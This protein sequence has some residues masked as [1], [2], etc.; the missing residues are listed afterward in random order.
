MK[1]LILIR[2][3]KSSWKNPGLPDRDRPLNKRGKRDAPVM[4]EHLAERGIEVDRVISSPTTR[5]LATAEVITEEIGFPWNEIIVDERLYHA[6]ALELL[7]V[8]RNLDDHLDCVMCFGH[9]PGLTD[10]VHH[11]SPHYIDNVPTCGV[12]E[13]KF[14]VDTWALVGEIEPLEVDFDYPKKKR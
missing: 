11:L 2:H 4:A 3:A 5:A 7:E 10:L 1:T 13:L 14:D 6:D 8:I 9:N 12:V